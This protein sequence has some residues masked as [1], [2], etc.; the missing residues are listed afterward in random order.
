[1]SASAS[2]CRRLLVQKPTSDVFPLAASDRN[3][4]L[5]G[6][7]GATSA[8]TSTIPD[9]S[10]ALLARL[11][12]LADD[13]RQRNSPEL[14]VGKQFVVRNAIGSIAGRIHKRIDDARRPGHDRGEDLQPRISVLVVG[15]VDQ[16]QRQEAHEEAEENRQHH[17]GQ[18]GILTIA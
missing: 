6:G 11:I 3:M 1:M 18:T 2:D 8:T 13:R 16:H 4:L 10:A 17:A 5:A 7:L 9:A 14:Q 15:H 12:A